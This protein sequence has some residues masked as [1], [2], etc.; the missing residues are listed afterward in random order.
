MSERPQNGDYPGMRD[1]AASLEGLRKDA[2]V[3][4]AADETR[5]Y[6]NAIAEF[7]SSLARLAAACEFDRAQQQDLLQEIHLA[8]WRSFAGFR[9]QCSLRTWVYRVA[10]N[11]AAT[12]V[13][14]QKRAGVSRLI[15][16]EE[17]EDLPGDSDAERSLDESKILARLMT[18]IQRL[19]PLDRDVMLLYL[20]G[21]SASAIGEV[22]GLS[23][24]NVAQKIHRTKKVLQRHF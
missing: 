17:L 21:T 2:T 15:S 13:R 23:P 10:H 4:E 9:N 18:L 12:H 22:T 11:T 6:D 14:R 20:E 19:K 3:I 1:R 24:A 8:L 7:G 16:L 5:W